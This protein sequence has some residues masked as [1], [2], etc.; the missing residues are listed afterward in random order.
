M[1]NKKGAALMQVLLITVVLAGMSIM[2]LRVV[3]SRTSSARITRR[4]VLAEQLIE[5]CM[6]EVNSLWAYKTPEAFKRD[7]EGYA[8]EYKPIMYC[9]SQSNNGS[10][11]SQNR[12]YTYTCQYG[13]TVTPQIITAEFVKD[14]HVKD[15][16]NTDR[17]VWKLVYT[18]T[19]ANQL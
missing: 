19:T 18:I 3:L 16:G 9:K 6:A 11:A 7:M 10:C 17:T 1:N 4:S 15:T 12:V 5:G 8:P 2:L 13:E 14:T